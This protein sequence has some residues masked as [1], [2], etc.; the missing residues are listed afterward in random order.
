[1]FAHWLWVHDERRDGLHLFDCV[2]RARRD[3]LPSGQLHLCWRVPHLQRKH[4]LG[5]RHGDFVH[6]VC[7]WPYVW[8]GRGCLLRHRRR[9]LRGHGHSADGA[10]DGVHEHRDG[11]FRRRQRLQQHHGRLND[12]PS[13]V[14]RLHGRRDD[15]QVLRGLRHEVRHGGRLVRHAQPV[16]LGRGQSR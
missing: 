11:L 10:A 3:I 15:L 7:K 2:P 9:R 16:Q 12:R 14:E 5:G 6:G 8:R 13:E 1:M 4:V